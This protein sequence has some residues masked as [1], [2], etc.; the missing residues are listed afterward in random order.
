[1]FR[2]SKVTQECTDS[3][4][5]IILLCK[6]CTQRIDSL[7]GPNCW[8]GDWSSGLGSTTT[9]CVFCVLSSMFQVL[10]GNCGDPVS[11]Y[12]VEWDSSDSF[13]SA[14]LSSA[15]LDGDSLL[16]EEQVRHTICCLIERA[17]LKSGIVSFSDLN[18][19][20]RFPR[21]ITN[22]CLGS[23]W[24][25]ALVKH[26]NIHSPAVGTPPLLRFLRRI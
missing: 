6:S 18:T 5:D 7:W 10:L 25:K 16:V 24:I 19:L 1:M 9:R 23:C 12:I 22:C 3:P 4:S 8:S 26:E 14:A 11:Y 20:H 21:G 17:C 2:T 15:T 13:N